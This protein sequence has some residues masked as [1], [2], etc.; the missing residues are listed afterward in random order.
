MIKE[1]VVEVKVLVDESFDSDVL[2]DALVDT[3]QSMSY[4][5][6]ID[7]FNIHVEDEE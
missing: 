6:G 4:Q 3:L 7:A 2:V 5:Q 1:I